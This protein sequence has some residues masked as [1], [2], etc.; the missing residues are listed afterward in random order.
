MPSATCHSDSAGT[1]PSR[2]FVCPVRSYLIVLCLPELAWILLASLGH[3]HAGTRLQPHPLATPSPLAKPN[4][5][6]YSHIHLPVRYT[7][8]TRLEWRSSRPEAT[9]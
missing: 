8:G 3:P 6:C 5:L 4:L 1:Y 2:A 9:S 7:A